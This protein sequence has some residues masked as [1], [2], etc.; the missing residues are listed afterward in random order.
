MYFVAKEKIVL[1]L[2][3]PLSISIGVAF[4]TI[5][6]PFTGAGL[7]AELIGISP[8]VSGI[9]GCIPTLDYF[10]H[11]SLSNQVMENF[12]ENVFTE[13][14]TEVGKGA[15]GGSLKEIETAEKTQ[16]A[17]VTQGGGELSI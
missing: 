13:S 6:F 17:I 5:A 10:Q 7:M 2:G 9:Y 16:P 15:I 12:I 1:A 4:G 11:N 14:V 8:D 3:S